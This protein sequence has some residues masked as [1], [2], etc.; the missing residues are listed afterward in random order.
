ARI[1]VAIAEYYPKFSLGG[2]IGSATTMGAGNL[3][4]GRANQAAGVLGLR[5]LCID[6]AEIEQTPA[7][8]EHARS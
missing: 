7:Q 3:F 8:A 2:L 4:A 5:D 1:G 6:P